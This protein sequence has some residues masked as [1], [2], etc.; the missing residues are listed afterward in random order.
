MANKTIKGEPS[1]DDMHDDA[2]SIASLLEIGSQCSSGGPALLLHDGSHLTH[3]DLQ[4]LVVQAEADL[5]R[6]G[7]GRRTRV[8][9]ALPD[10]PLTACVLLALTRSAICAPVNPDLRRAEVEILIP[11]LGAEVLVAHG[12]CADEARRAAA[13]LSLPIIE[14]SW[15]GTKSLH[16][17]GPA[18][19]SGPAEASVA[20]PDDTALILLTSGSSARPKRVP[21]SHR[22]L[23][24]SAA[25]MARSLALTASDVC[26]NM[27]PMFH[28][29]AVVDLLLAPLSVGGSLT[30]PETMSVPAFFEAL[31]KL[32]PTWFQGVP[33][34]LHELAVHA[35]RRGG[36]H[37]RST[38]RLVRSVSS[39]LPPEWINEIEA[40][41]GAPV[42][43]IYGMTET[44]GVITSN[45]LP[46]ELRKVGSVGRPTASMEVIVRDA[47]GAQAGVSARGEIMVR[48][49]G[50]MTGYEKLDSQDRGL[51]EDG[52]L[53]TGDE[54]YFDADGFLFITGR[55]NDQ[56]NRGGEKVSPREIDEVLVSHPGV[57]DAAA[58]AV[59][60]PHLGQDVAAA[61]VAK[62]GTTLTAEELTT[63][64]SSQLAYFKV[65]KAFYLVPELPRG[66]GGKL[67]RRLLPEMVRDL[68]PLAHAEADAAEAP[69]TDMEKRVA[70]WWESELK[71][72]GIG[73][74]GDFFELGGDSLTAAAF[75]VGIE[76]LLGIQVRPAALFDHPT[77]TS[78]ARYLEGAMASRADSAAVSVAKPE[79]AMNPDLHRR[80][81]AA[82]SVWPG[83]RRDESS[84]LVGLR[85]EGHGTP[86]FWCGQGRPEY[87]SIVEQLP[88]EHPI[89]GTRSLYLFEGKKRQDEEA[90]A[91]IFANEVEQLRAGREVIL[92][93]F[94]AGGRIA[95][96]AACHLRSRGVPVKM[97]FMHET[98]STQPIDVP[99][100]LGFTVDSTF[101]PYREYARP[102][103][104]MNKRFTAG[105]SLSMFRTAH[106]GI[107]A[108]EPL[109]KEVQK[110]RSLW[111]DPSKFQ[112][113]APMEGVPGIAYR[114]KIES[115]FHTPV[116]LIG[117]PGFACVKVTNLSKQTWLPAARSGLHLGQRWL[118]NEGKVVG[119]PGPSVPLPKVVPP[120]KSVTFLVKIP[121][122]NTQGLRTLEIDMVDEGICWF[123][124]KQSQHPSQ[125]LRLQ[126][127]V[128]SLFPHRSTPPNP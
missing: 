47:S 16:W 100:A 51:T 57:Q 20:E 13:A 21:L 98:W 15:E 96:D 34:L 27:M 95:F 40:A 125:P 6:L 83:V 109:S 122:S 87:D 80:L 66:P 26:L 49:A 50:V 110:L 103:V 94:C 5:R 36:A 41:L 43:E 53:K 102:E 115:R 3:G 44:A 37:Q 54:G 121:A 76:K 64:V 28:V 82:M 111:T 69:Q 104:V 19:T 68:Q 120:G 2:G 11:E 65:P 45:P 101:S 105:W 108:A 123:S 99:V 9:T 39:P 32:R 86:I 128:A 71:V 81:L 107:Y 18:L 38:L 114:A 8:M 118:D 113:P 55:I 72:T 117:W 4:S 29:G 42:I 48:G 74:N 127:K 60:H 10:S 62:P 77:V 52:W 46:P 73:R 22:H 116:L 119:D 14:V 91:R 12:A 106:N 85:T 33:T 24:L 25:R 126:L 63:H 59:P 7:I 92:G 35:L 17:S 79:P 78:F 1:P 56:I 58:F 88:P 75:T 84:L 112:R 89:Y 31:E 23:T 61:V 67:R 97:V 124:E 30:R 93:G 90:L 70:G